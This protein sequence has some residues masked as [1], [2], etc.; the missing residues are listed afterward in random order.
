VVN[1]NTDGAALTGT[2]GGDRTP[3]LAAG[4]LQV[5][6]AA[7]GNTLSGSAIVYVSD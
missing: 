7:G 1:G 3:I 5:V 6:I 2:A 4:R